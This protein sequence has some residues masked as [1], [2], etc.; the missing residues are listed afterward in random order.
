MSYE[1]L[2]PYEIKKPLEITGDLQGFIPTG[3]EPVTFGFGGTLLA[4]KCLLWGVISGFRHLPLMGNW[5]E[6][7]LQVKC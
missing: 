6:T 3:F 4:C 5:S 1:P 2:T 7:P